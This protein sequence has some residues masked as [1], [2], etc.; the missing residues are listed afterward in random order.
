LLKLLLE[1]SFEHL[2][3]AE[4]K[5]QVLLVLAAMLSSLVTA[6]LHAYGQN[7][8]MS[9]TMEFDMKDGWTIE[10]YLEYLKHLLEQAE[11]AGY[12]AG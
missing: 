9:Q 4:T 7:L 1:K 5:R 3:G 11:E 12:T 8:S 10:E 6:V 2:H